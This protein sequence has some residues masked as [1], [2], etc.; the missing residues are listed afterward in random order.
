MIKLRLLRVAKEV[1][2]A[3]HALVSYDVWLVGAADVGRWLPP[4]QRHKLL[5]RYVERA[6]LLG[7]ILRRVVA[8]R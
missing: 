8:L 4:C 1:V 2:R 6:G 7:S 3:I 5:R